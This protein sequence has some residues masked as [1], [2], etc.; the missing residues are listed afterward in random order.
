MDRLSRLYSNSHVT[1]MAP[2]A[3][4]PPPASTPPPHPAPRPAHKEDARPKDRR[5]RERGEED[6][7]R[8]LRLRLLR[9]LPQ[10]GQR[11]IGP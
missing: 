6:L 3:P 11:G 1:R 7:A 2:A 9:L 10:D 8:G 5:R 4:A